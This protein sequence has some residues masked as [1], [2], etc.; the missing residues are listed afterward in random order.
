[1]KY[2]LLAITIL[3]IFIGSCSENITSS[4]CNDVD[5]GEFGEC[6]NESGAP[7]CLCDTG[8]HSDVLKCISDDV[9][10]CKYVTC[11]NNAT[12][13]PSS[14]NCDCDTGYHADGKSC[15][16][17]NTNLCKDIICQD[18]ATCNSNN[19]ECACNVGYHVDGDNCIVDA[20]E[21]ADIRIGPTRDYKTAAS[22]QTAIQDGY[23]IEID[24]GT[25]S[26]VTYWAQNNITIRGN[27]RVIYD[28]TD[29][30]I[31]NK[32]GIWVIQG[33]N[34]TVEN[35]EF[36]GAAVGDRNGAGIRYEGNGK[37][38]I[39]NCYFHHNEDGLLTG[40]NGSEDITIIGSE[41]HDHGKSNGGFSH[42]IYI[43]KGAKFTMI[44]SY[45]HDAYEGHDVK[46]RADENYILYNRIV[47]H[48]DW[49]ADKAS[50]Y[51]L[52][53]P[54][55]GLS[56]V[57][58]N[59]FHQSTKASNPASFSYAKENTNGPIQKLYV[60]NNTFVNS[61]ANNSSFINLGGNP[62]INIQNNIINN[63]TAFINGDYTGIF[64]NNEEN[65]TFVDKDAMN[66]E[67]TSESLGINSG[68]TLSSQNG[69][70]LI[71]SSEYSHPK[72]LKDR[73][74]N[75]VIDIGAHELK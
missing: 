73:L 26:D 2:I 67:L 21:E 68:V 5:C 69:V 49:N 64:D 59:E 4:V 48:N 38:T 57:I 1:M 70:N 13:N 25:Y 34:V 43:G 47:D 33:N 75:G 18:N 58:G 36:T 71:P 42:N 9:D 54:E 35:I 65:P 39:K 41:F 74:I 22:A 12:C 63:Y 16:I 7:S 30:Y 52:D 19:G 24:E 61:K 6:I 60:I 23:V 46:S 50:S 55:G 17:D 66:Y 37:L 45:S 56:F 28:L 15:I 51:L 31:Q 27:G 62:E 20:I 3:I 40:N 8:Y 29:T 72:T 10:F 32:K 14:G 53:L 11:Q 44:N